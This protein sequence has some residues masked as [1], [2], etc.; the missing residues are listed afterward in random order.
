VQF[1]V[2]FIDFGFRRSQGLLTRRRDLVNPPPSSSHILKGRF[3]QSGALQTVQKRIKSSRTNAISVML[4]FLHHRQ[5][6]DWLVIGMKKHMDPNQ[7]EKKFSLVA[8]HKINIPPLTLEAVI[9]NLNCPACYR[10]S[11]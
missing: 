1:F 3:Q 11:I 6:E 5:T 4:Q 9:N 2:E 8:R 10:T 7:S